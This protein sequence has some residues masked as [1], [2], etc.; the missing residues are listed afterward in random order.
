MGIRTEMAKKKVSAFAIRCRAVS[1]SDELSGRSLT[2]AA[3]MGSA[4]NSAL[5]AQR[6][7]ALLAVLWLAVAL[8]F[9]GMATAQLVRTEVSALTNQIDWQ[10]SYYLARGGIEAAVYAIAQPNLAQLEQAE[11]SDTPSQFRPGKRW[12]QFEFPGGSCTVEVI[13]ENAKLNINQAPPEQLTILFESLG[14][15]P[16]ESLDLAAAIVEWRS[17]RTSDVDSPLDIFYT[18]LPQPY[19]AWHASL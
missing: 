3:L 15:P 9:M 11:G 7:V 1:Q 5:D 16:N 18:R 13:P 2:V 19:P 17:P 6:G 4:R 8:S 12:L 14:L 10:R